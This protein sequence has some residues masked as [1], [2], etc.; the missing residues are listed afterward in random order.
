MGHDPARILKRVSWVIFPI[1]TAWV[2]W[3]LLEQYQEIA[4]SFAALD[5]GRLVYSQVAFAASIFPMIMAYTLI[6]SKLSGQK[7]HFSTMAPIFLISQVGKYLPGKIWGMIYLAEKS[8][9]FASKRT[10]WIANGMLLIATMTQNFLVGAYLLTYYL[11]GYELAF[12]LLLIGQLF[13]ILSF[14]SRGMQSLAWA[15]LR[16]VSPTA[17]PDSV[18]F[19]FRESVFLVLLLSIEWLLYLL[20]WDIMLPEQFGWLDS[21]FVAFS[22]IMA[23]FAGFL[24][25]AIPSGL[26]VREAVFAWIGTTFGAG[27]GFLVFYGVLSRFLF[28]L[29]ELLLAIS[30]AV[31]IFLNKQRLKHD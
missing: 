13:F 22:Y 7:I 18:R 20:C 1:A 21:C 24:V 14:S 17:T 27:A 31:Y 23:W 11:V 30:A 29:T 2:G 10:S 5:F 16:R 4:A 26:F 6:L 3:I 25:V 8:N 9:S 19:S 15:I 28:T 12:I